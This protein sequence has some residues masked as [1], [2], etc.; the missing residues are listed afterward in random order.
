MSAL[1]RGHT[2]SHEGFVLSVALIGPVCT[3]AGHDRDGPAGQ[4]MRWGSSATD[5][6]CDARHAIAWSNRGKQDVACSQQI[7]TRPPLPSDTN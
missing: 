1:M 6:Q 2:G 5:A 7:G 3:L 4:P